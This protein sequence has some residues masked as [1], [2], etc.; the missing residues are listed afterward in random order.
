MGD[1]LHNTMF[2]S[3]RERAMAYIVQQDSD[4]QGLFFLRGNLYLL[5]AEGLYGLLHK[6]H[7]AQG[8]M[9]A[10]MPCSRID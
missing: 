3:M 4:I 2:H 1:P 8:M 10:R 7:T 9:K 6:K 5:V